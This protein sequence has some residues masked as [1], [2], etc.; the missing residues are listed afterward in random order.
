MEDTKIPFIKGGSQI[1]ITLSTGI[2]ADLQATLSYLI[3]N[4]TEDEIGS[5]QGRID[6]R[7][8]LEGW[9]IG[10]VTLTRLLRDIQTTAEA[11][12]QIEMRSISDTITSVVS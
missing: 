11:T 10:I 3:T 9:E 5:I 1:P 7:Q 2:I 8:Q 4:R 12:G 6:T